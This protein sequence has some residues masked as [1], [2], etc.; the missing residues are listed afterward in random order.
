MLDL[1]RR[2]K[3]IIRPHD[4]EVIKISDTESTYVVSP[5][6]EGFGISI[7]NSLRRVL[8]SSVGGFAINSVKIDNIFHE[9]ETIDGI[10][11]DVF[12]IIMNIKNIVFT[13]NTTTPSKLFIKSNKKG[14]VLAESIRV[15]GGGEVV[16]KELV[17]CNIEKDKAVFNAELTVDY[18]IGYSPVQFGASKV[19]TISVDAL[20]NSVKNVSCKVEELVIENR[21]I[22]DKLMV[23]VV[24]NGAITPDEA[25]IF[26]SKVLQ[27]QLDMFISLDKTQKEDKDKSKTEEIDILNGV[28]PAL[29][30]K[31]DD[32]ELTVRSSNCLKKIGIVY[33]GE[34]VQRERAY[35]MNLQNFGKKSLEDLEAS[36]KILELELG[37][38]IDNW[39]EMI[40]KYEESGKNK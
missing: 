16:N 37:M 21:Y 20:Y 35:M 31:I 27:S 3:D 7:G 39:K 13:K 40:K 32:I 6:P 30:K 23:N 38:K 5:L 14:P 4:I 10:R 29:F 17:I 28:N 26:A 19:G 18:G 8:L 25:V 33:L 24:T 15:E 1:Q 22:Q 12:E 36:L 34:L 9:Y 2:W 11:E